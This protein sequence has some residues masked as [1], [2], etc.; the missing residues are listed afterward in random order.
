MASAWSC[1]ILGTNTLCT[2]HWSLIRKVARLHIRFCKFLVAMSSRVFPSPWTFWPN[3]GAYLCRMCAPMSSSFQAF[4][5]VFLRTCLW[6]PFFPCVI[7]RGPWVVWCPKKRG[8]DTS[9][10]FR[11]HWL[12]TG[13]NPESTVGK[14]NHLHCFRLWLE[15]TW[16]SVT[17]CLCIVFSELDLTLHRARVPLPSSP[18]AEDKQ[19]SLMSIASTPRHTPSF[20]HNFVTRH[21]SHT[22][23]SHTLSHTQLPT[24][25]SELSLRI[26]LWNA[27]YVQ[28]QLSYSWHEWVCERT[29]KQWKKPCHSQ[30]RMKWIGSW[31]FPLIVNREM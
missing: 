2:K 20:T 18:W 15:R 17:W 14:L 7:A 11:T 6:V 24:T 30:R 16:N 12:C 9:K 5:L 3:V 31:P 22:T 1:C 23:L 4:R 26:L 13:W 28:K 27:S 19:G 25:C 8:F 29:R 21:L 10:A